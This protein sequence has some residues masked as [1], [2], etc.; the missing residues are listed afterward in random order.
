M[1]LGHSLFSSVVRDDNDSNSGRILYSSSP[2]HLLFS[3]SSSSSSRNY[4]IFPFS[5]ISNDRIFM[6]YSNALLPLITLG[7]FKV[8]FFGSFD[9]ATNTDQIL[10]GIIKKRLKLK[11]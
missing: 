11:I 3:F 4:F 7:S 8:E 5:Y 6:P 2:S 9:E 10:K 1:K